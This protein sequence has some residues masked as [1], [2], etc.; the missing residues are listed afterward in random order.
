MD[1]SVVIPV[2]GCPAALSDLY[3]RLT[4]TLQ[5]M[6]QS[7]E[8]IWVNDACPKN[9]WEIIELICKGDSHV[10]GLELSR[11]FGQIKATT[12][13]L[14]YSSGDW[15]VVMDCDLQDKP[16]EIRVM[17]QKAQEG[18]D[19]VFARRKNRQDSKIKVMISKCF[20]KIYSYAADTKYDPALC[21]FSIS[22]RKGIYGYCSM[23]ELHRAFIMYIMWM[24][25]RQAVVDV[26][27][28]ERYEGKSGYNLKKRIKMAVEILTSQSDKV[29][30]WT[31]WMGFLIALLSLASVII[32]I[33]KYFSMDI[34]PGYS[35]LIS[36]VFLMGGLTIMTIGVVG[37]YVGN[38]FMEVKRRPLYLV[39]TVLNGKGTQTKD[40][41]VECVGK[42]WQL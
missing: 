34:Q 35:S 4:R 23:R 28:D 26:E 3:R 37:I 2:Y 27:H 9:S 36:A 11:N 42:T 10:V 16:E 13:G 32:H 33:I 8:I 19:V 15:V 21:N 7:Y 25:F 17:Y 1:I 20:Y 6:T 18:Y 12:A 31:V 22:S 14:D 41:A 5:D 40:V 39:R 30:K 38:I 24:G 29:L